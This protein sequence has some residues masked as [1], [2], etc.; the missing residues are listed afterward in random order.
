[1]KKILLAILIL[2]L[3]ACTITTK[4]M[5]LSAWNKSDVSYVRGDGWGRLD[6]NMDQTE[7]PIKALNTLQGIK[8]AD[9]LGDVAKTGI[10]SGVDLAKDSNATKLGSQELSNA[11]KKA[12]LNQA[13]QLG[14]I[15]AVE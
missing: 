2:F 5:G 3:S 7:V 11:A 15:G 4:N 9:E 14:E 10:K 12:E 13:V 1:M 6:I 8:I